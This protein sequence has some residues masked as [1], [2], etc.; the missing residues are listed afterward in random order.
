MTPLIVHTLSE[1]ISEVFHDSYQHCRGYVGN[2]FLDVGLQVT[3]GPW[4]VDINSGFQKTPQEKSQGAKSRERSCIG[5][6]TPEVSLAPP[7]TGYVGRNRHKEM[8]K[9]RMYLNFRI[10]CTS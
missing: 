8:M 2:V 10:M 5:H 7:L 4:S 1:P 3:H 6:E 9:K